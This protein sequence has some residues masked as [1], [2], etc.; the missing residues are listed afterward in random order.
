MAEQNFQAKAYKNVGKTT[1]KPNA[2]A[3]PFEE[4]VLGVDWAEEW[5]LEHGT[6][7]ESFVDIYFNGE[8][9]IHTSVYY[10]KARQ[11]SQEPLFGLANS[12][13]A[14][15]PIEYIGVDEGNIDPN[16]DIFG[17]DI[18]DWQPGDSDTDEVDED[19]DIL[20]L[21]KDRPEKPDRKPKNEDDADD[22]DDEEEDDGDDEKEDDDAE[23]DADDEPDEEE[24]E[25]PRLTIFSKM[26]GPRGWR[27]RAETDK[28]R[29][30]NRFS[31]KVGVLDETYD[32]PARQ[33]RNTLIEVRFQEMDS[34]RTHGELR[35]LVPDGVEFNKSGRYL[36]ARIPYKPGV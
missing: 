17:R 11:G 22:E 4:P 15:W 13:H 7:E 30:I 14:R 2:E 18:S 29:E 9:G 34:N 19:A 10:L 8:Q 25:M 21:G 24:D 6:P 28:D 26:R 35:I 23:D 32:K 1:P 27:K 3:G 5:L 20:D 12:S 33:E 36:T 16:S 31:F